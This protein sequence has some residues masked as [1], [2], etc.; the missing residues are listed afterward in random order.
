M[1][2]PWLRAALL[3]VGAS[4]CVAGSK[5]Y[6]AGSKRFGYCDVTDEARGIDCTNGIKGSWSAT[7]TASN[8]ASSGITN[9]N[10]CA[11]RCLRC[12]RCNFISY[13]MEQGDCSWFHKCDLDNLTH[14]FGFTSAIVKGT[15][16]S[17]WAGVATPL[18]VP[19]H[20]AT[21][22]NG[23]LIDIPS[24]ASPMLLEI[25][26]S[27]RNTLDVE[28]LQQL[29]DAFLLTL[30]PLIDKYARALTRRKPQESVVDTL[31]PLGKHHDRGIILPIAVAPAPPG[32]EQ[33]TFY[34]AGGCSSLLSVAHR[35]DFG[36]WC[37]KIKE[38]R[39]VWT[40][41][42][43]TV[44]GWVGTRVDFLKIDA[45]GMDLAIIQSAGPLLHR[46]VARFQLEVVSDDCRSLYENQPRCSEVV[47]ASR[48]LGFE[49]IGDFSC[50][51]PLGRSHLNHACE[52]ELVFANSQLHGKPHPEYVLPYQNVAFNGC[53]EAYPS[54]RQEALR[55][56]PPPGK[57]VAVRHKNVV[58]FVSDAWRGLSTHSHGRSYMCPCACIE[59]SKRAAWGCITNSEPDT[60]QGCILF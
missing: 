47:N 30:E 52:L 39:A 9:I 11:L 22:V 51:P 15:N 50:W 16:E 1:P 60:E 54:Q 3:L 33:R 49:P 7:V 6:D 2:A 10:Q 36:E 18:I 4:P 48:M 24:T 20:A 13:S 57:V 55:R 14:G 42:L 56:N 38:T 29:P 12:A 35:I 25:G 32:G 53:R 17:H 23:V 59:P 27:D 21:L 37:R 45:Q 46:R 31:E 26:S 5:Q 41:P 40:V 19:V 43:S 58:M 44:L 8:H 34:A 28:L